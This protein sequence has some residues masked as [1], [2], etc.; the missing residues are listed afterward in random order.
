MLRLVCVCAL[1]KGDFMGR[2][3]P[4]TRIK[5]NK[6]DFSC[7]FDM[8]ENFFYPSPY[9]ES[10]KFTISQYTQIKWKSCYN[11]NEHRLKS[12]AK[13]L[14]ISDFDD[15]TWLCCC[16][17]FSRSYLKTTKHDIAK[18]DTN[19]TIHMHVR[20]CA[21]CSLFMDY[22]RDTSNLIHRFTN[23]R[24]ILKFVLQAS[25]RMEIGSKSNLNYMAHVVDLASWRYCVS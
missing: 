5:T 10:S 15:L 20:V 19:W 14:E 22:W 12:F 8:L 25:K 7:V 1:I 16:F 6:F 4:H 2:L 13:R 18:P 11:E 3:I 17:F 23:R 24:I 9:I 21:T